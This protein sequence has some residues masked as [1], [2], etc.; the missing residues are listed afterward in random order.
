MQVGLIGFG[1]LGKLM[2]SHLAKDCD[3][4]IYDQKSLTDDIEKQGAKTAT[5][6]EV[7]SCQLILLAVP[8]SEIENTCRSISPYIKE[9]A[10]VLD[11]CSVKEKPVAWMEE[12]LPKHAQIL[13]THPMFGPDSAKNTLFGLKMVL[14]PVRIEDYYLSNI[15][16]Y[17]QTH[18]I[19]VI[20]AS[21]KEH[22]EQMAH[23]LLLTHFIGRGLL[24]F[25]ATDLLIDTKG[26]RR[27]MKILETV[28]NDSWQ[29]FKDM[30]KY[31]SYAEK[32]RQDFQNS[33][34]NVA[35]RLDE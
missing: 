17:L 4:F 2:A 3:L 33:L 1:R 23:T 10:V 31:N 5:L 28:E 22:D 27:L 15:T 11:F 20:N 32:T 18:G 21:P 25:G 16:K 7:S 29:L 8:I 24:D 19:K 30:N 13:G 6:K 9:G 14:C 26:Y 12:L 34:I 35:K